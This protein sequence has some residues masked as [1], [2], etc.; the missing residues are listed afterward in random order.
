MTAQNGTV[1]KNPNTPY[2][3]AGSTVELT[4]AP[5]SGYTFSGWSGDASGTASPTT[6]TMSGNK[7]VT[8]SF[9]PNSVAVVTDVATVNVPEGA[10]ATFQV[11]LSAQPT[12]AVTVAV[13]RTAG[14]TDLGVSGGA[15]LSFTTGNWASYQTVTLAAAEDNTDNVSG[16]ATISCDADL[17]GCWTPA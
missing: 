4:A 5:N 2:Y 12:G 17:A 1:T 8:A 13:G 9:T 10:T 11:R 6:V 16:S 3:D 15:S 7:A 14:D